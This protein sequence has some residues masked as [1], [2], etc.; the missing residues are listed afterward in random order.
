MNE[1]IFNED[2]LV[3][4]ITDL[5]LSVG[6]MSKSICFPGPCEIPA[7][8][9]DYSVAL[10]AHCQTIRGANPDRADFAVSHRDIVWRAH[11]D[12][13]AIDGEWYRLRR[14]PKSAPHL[15][16]EGLPSKLPASIVRVLLQPE[17]RAGG[18]LFICGPT[19][20]G[21]TTTASATVRSRLQTF[22]GM[23]YTV[24]DPPEHPLNG[25]HVGT[26]GVRGYCTQTLVAHRP[27]KS[28]EDGW[29]AAMAGALRSQPAGTPTILYVGEIRTKEAADVAIQAAGNGFLV[30]V[31]GF[32]T[33]IPSG[34]AALLKLL[35]TQRA[36]TLAQLLRVVLFQRLADSRLRGAEGEPAPIDAKVIQAQICV[37]PS[38][39]SRV[40]TV[41]AGGNLGRLQDEVQ[42]QSNLVRS[43]T[44]LWKTA[45]GQ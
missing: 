6:D 45:V 27:E 1:A 21:K 28:S 35:G 16:E 25:W 31:T 36:E 34:V 14:M 18:L 7:E 40:A 26:G 44:D 22:G 29:S 17:L 9:Q 38:G 37:S 12:Q 8:F 20:S 42:L 3:T 13:D 33:D 41:I 5:A 43:E 32:A 11:F 15:G 4:S 30:V 39:S 19:G 2:G 23:A 24:E 10:L